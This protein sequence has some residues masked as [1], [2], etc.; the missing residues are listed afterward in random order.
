M[1]EEARSSSGLTEGEAK[2]FHN[3][4]M[5]SMAAFFAM[6]LFAHALIWFWRPWFG[7]Y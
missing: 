6:N 3:V 4:L 5:V 7:P 2:E 1:A